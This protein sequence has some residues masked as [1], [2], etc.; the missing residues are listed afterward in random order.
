MGGG[1][2]EV[3]T[4]NVKANASAKEQL[5]GFKSSQLLIYQEWLRLS[6]KLNQSTQ[7]FCSSRGDTVTLIYVKP[8]KKNMAC[9]LR[10]TSV[11]TLAFLS[12]EQCTSLFLDPA[13]WRWGWRSWI[14]ELWLLQLFQSKTGSHLFSVSTRA[15]DLS[16]G[17]SQYKKKKGAGLQTSPL[18]LF[19]L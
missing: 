1:C 16:L 10:S 11:I 18:K 2:S 17:R 7:G 12:W 4:S 14:L 15:N 19:G 8:K 3:V 5:V 6:S 13:N 9:G